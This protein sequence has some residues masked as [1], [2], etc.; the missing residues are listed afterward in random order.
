VWRIVP[1]SK[2][3]DV[4]VDHAAIVARITLALGWVVCRQ[5]AVMNDP[6]GHVQLLRSVPRSGT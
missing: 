1:G 4:D 3:P 5:H 2:D 6:T